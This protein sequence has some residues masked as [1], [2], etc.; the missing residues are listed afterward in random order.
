MS[1]TEI[2][3]WIQLF[4]VL[5]GGIIGFIAFFQN[6]KQRRIENAMKMTKWFHESI[7][8]EELESWETLFRASSELSGAKL[9]SYMEKGEARSLSEYFSE[10]SP[11][12]GAVGRIADCLEVI[13]HELS[14]KTVDPR[15]I[16]F[17][18][19]QLLKTIHV[20]LNSIE[21]SSGKNLLETSYPSFYK[22]FK[23]YNIKFDKWP[24]RTY[25]YIE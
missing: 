21:N 11:D 14:E 13:C 24:S 23:K 15:F 20:W 3:N 5:I 19:G 4:A 22:A 8:M 18:L 16:W 17:E 7:S 9:G 25:A 10:G 2:R 12:A 6:M 1:L